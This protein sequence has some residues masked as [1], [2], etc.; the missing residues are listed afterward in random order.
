MPTSNSE[1][2][3][4]CHVVIVCYVAINTIGHVNKLQHLSVVFKL[5]AI[6]T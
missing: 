1:A 2:N 3:F 5:L 4:D 6:I